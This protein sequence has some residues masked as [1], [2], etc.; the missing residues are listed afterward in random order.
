MYAGEPYLATKDLVVDRSGKLLEMDSGVKRTNKREQ[1][2]KSRSS[3][4]PRRDGNSRFMFLAIPW[5]FGKKSFVTRPYVGRWSLRSPPCAEM[6]AVSGDFY[7]RRCGKTVQ[8]RQIGRAS[9]RERV[10]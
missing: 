5:K 3:Y 4:K 7:G 2:E 9:C 1:N 10:F 8:M 6:T